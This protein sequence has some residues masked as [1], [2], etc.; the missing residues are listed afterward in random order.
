MKPA[1]TVFVERG[2]NPVTEYTGAIV[3]P[4]GRGELVGDHELWIV[5]RPIY[6]KYYARPL[7]WWECIFYRFGWRVHP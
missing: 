5:T 4:F 2:S 6:G 3:R 1:A 7:R